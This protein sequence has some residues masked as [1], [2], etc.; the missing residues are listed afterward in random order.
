MRYFIIVYVGAANRY[1]T[2]TIEDKS[3]QTISF[4][5]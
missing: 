5:L 1:L 3:Q 4:N 2:L